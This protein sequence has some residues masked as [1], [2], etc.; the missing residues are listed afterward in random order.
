MAGQR[1]WGQ[2]M[3]YVGH[4]PIGPILDGFLLKIGVMSAAE[5][6][7]YPTGVDAKRGKICE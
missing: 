1:C 5:G 2:G 4:E 6:W 7:S 3:P